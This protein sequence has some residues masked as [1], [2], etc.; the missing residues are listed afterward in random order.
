MMHT[1]QQPSLDSPAVEQAPMV[2][3]VVNTAKKI[4]ASKAMIF[5]PVFASY[6]LSVLA[7]ALTAYLV[8]HLFG[9]PYNPGLIQ[10]DT[11][12]WKLGIPLSLIVAFLLGLF[13]P[14]LFARSR[15]LQAVFFTMILLFLTLV[16]LVIVGLSQLSLIAGA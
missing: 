4:Q 7:A 3:H 1:Q 6:L 9:S 11:S 2:E 8:N 10:Y 14:I 15:K 13:L 12:L 16:I 5:W